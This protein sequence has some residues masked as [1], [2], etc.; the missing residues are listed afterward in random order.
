MMTCRRVT[1]DMHTNRRQYQ[2]YFCGTLKDL[3]YLKSIYMKQKGNIDPGD[4]NI[5]SSVLAILVVC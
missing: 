2:L 4:G 3:V 5:R 1:D